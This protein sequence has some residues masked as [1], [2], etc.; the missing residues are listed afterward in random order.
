LL[1][2]AGGVLMARVEDA[3]AF[4]N[5]NIPEKP[6]PANVADSMQ[7]MQFFVKTRLEWWG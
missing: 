7:D 3:G 1:V 2:L 4:C 6:E 5:E